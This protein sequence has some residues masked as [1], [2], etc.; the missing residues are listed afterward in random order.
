MAA[1][2]FKKFGPFVNFARVDLGAVENK[3]KGLTMTG[4]KNLAVSL[5]TGGIVS[6][7]LVLPKTSTREGAAHSKSI[8]VIPILDEY[9]RY[10]SYIGLKLGSS[11]LHGPIYDSSYLTFSTRKDGHGTSS[12]AIQSRFPFHRVS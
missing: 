6:C 5:L 7:N 1:V 4:Q 9:E 8:S 3:F 2:R 12:D 11:S 10:I